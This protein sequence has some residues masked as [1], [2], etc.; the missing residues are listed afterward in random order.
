MK[1][2]GKYILDITN[3]FIKNC[4][5]TNLFFS[6]MFDQYVAFLATLIDFTSYI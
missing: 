4:W 3:I 2:F 1:A 6:Q 5:L